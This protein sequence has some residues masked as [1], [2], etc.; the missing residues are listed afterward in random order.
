MLDL[1]SFGYN[2]SLNMMKNS[3][4]QT[5]VM[6]WERAKTQQSFWILRVTESENSVRVV[7]Q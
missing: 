7:N 2:A 6:M 1:S 3:T 4:L 5:F